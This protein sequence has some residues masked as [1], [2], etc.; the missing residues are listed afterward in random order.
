[1]SADALTEKNE[2]PAAGTAAGVEIAEAMDE[3]SALG[4][5]Q[6]HNN[7]IAMI[8][9]LT[10]L[11][12]PGVVELSGNLVD[13][14]AGMLGKKTLDRGI[15]VEVEE[16]NVWVDLHVVLEYG[17][18]IPQVAWRIQNDVRQAITQMTNKNVRAVNVIV[19]SVRLPGEQK[20]ASQEECPS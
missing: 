4:A 5:I 18:A 7:V 3:G 2:R 15:H 16:N 17:I 10:T 20:A 14:L 9:R 12:I 1:M 19:Q 13:G 8:A 11:K 6:I